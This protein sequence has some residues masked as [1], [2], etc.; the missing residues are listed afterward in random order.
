MVTGTLLQ[1]RVRL[2]EH[3]QD[4]PRQV[5]IGIPSRK[6]ARIAAVRSVP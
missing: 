4:V 2:L 6:A 1:V 3:N 5:G